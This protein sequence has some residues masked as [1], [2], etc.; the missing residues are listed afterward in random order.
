MPMRLRPVALLVSALAL[1]MAGAAHASAPDP[2]RVW[3][4]F[5]PGAQVQV[6]R[7]LEG[8]G[9]RFHHRFDELRAFAV[10]LPPQAIDALRRNPAIELIEADPPRYPMAQVQPYGIGMVQAPQVWASGHEGDGVKVCVIDS[11]IHAAHEDF[12]GLTL[13]GHASAGQNWATDSCGHGSHVAGTIAGRD[14]G[15]GVVGV[16]RG[17]IPLHIVKVFDG[18]NCGWSYSSTLVN[19]AQQC[20]A[21]GAKVINMSLGGTSSSTTE[22]NAFQNLYNQGVLHVAAAGNGGNTRL[23]YPASYD[24]VISVA[25][26][27]SGKALASFSQRNSQVELAAPGVA[28]LSTVPQVSAT[29]A[30]AGV[31]YIASAFDGSHQGTASAALADG[32]RCTTTG[33]GSFAGKVV[34]CERG[35]ISFADKVRNVA[36]G[37]GVAAVIYNNAPGGF[38]GTL[39]SGAPAIPALSLSQEDGQ[40]LR[41]SRLGQLAAVSTIPVNAGNGYAYYDGTS[42]ASPHVAGVAALVWS[43]NPGW[44]NAQIREALAAT[45]EDLGAAGRDNSFGWGLVRAQAA[46]DYLGGGEPPPGVTAKVGTLTLTTTRRALQ[47]STR[48]DVTIVDAAGGSALGG[49][50]VTGCFS[51]AVTGCATGTTGTSGQ[52]SFSS[53]NYRNNAGSIGFCVT[54]VTGDTVVAFDDTGACRP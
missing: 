40:F 47:S 39:G 31:S 42:M 37:G 38:S 32:A 33:G 8:A 24:S 13:T 21:A 10:S 52:I 6:Q 53:G 27:D 7:A 9:A 3:V 16:A 18:P 44:T 25:A 48:A 11:G 36:N 23:S 2:D 14:N 15:V 30:V 22:R 17:Q 35:D 43:A 46:L 19:A 5:K 49:V 51:G 41:T 45:A 34:L 4:R 20:A 28:V 50:S 29:L 1:A 54:A 26:V 12:Q